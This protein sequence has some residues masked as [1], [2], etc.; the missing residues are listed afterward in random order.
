MIVRDEITPRAGKVLVANADPEIMRILEVNLVY[1]N[2]QV[3]PAHNS[4]EALQVFLQDKFDA[5]ILDQDVL[6]AEGAEISNRLKELSTNIPIILIG[7]QPP[8]KNIFSP[9]KTAMSYITKPFNPGEVVALIQRQLGPKDRTA[10]RLPA[11][12][13]ANK[14][15]LNVRS[16]RAT[17]TAS[18]SGKYPNTPQ[19]IDS[20]QLAMDVNRKEAREALNNIQRI[21]A[22]LMK[23]APPELIDSFDILVSDVQEMAVLGNRSLY[24][25]ADYKN[26]L[27]VQQERSQERDSDRSA[28]VVTVLAI[29]RNL[30]RSL[31]AKQLFSSESGKRVAKYSLAIAREMKMPAADIQALYQAG[32][33]KDL[34][35]AFS[36][37]EVIE[38]TAS[39]NRDAAAALKNKLNQIWKA[40]VP[41]SFLSPA[42]NLLVCL[43][44]RYDGTGGRFGLKGKDILLGA[45]VL[46]VADAFDRLTSVRSPRVQTADLAVDEVNKESG[47]SYDPHVVSA[48]LMLVK[49]N[50]IGPALDDI[51]LEVDAGIASRK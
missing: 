17:P 5:L 45:R 2:L 47:L 10:A 21:I 27:E 33:L 37:P 29:C 19:N 44:E 8:Q 43:P 30:A 34:A 16:K 50:E 13:Q 14:A 48:L 32:L 28:M 15:V 24:L 25:A 3:V 46:A 6:D 23:T 51:E 42:C 18:A 12:L 41:I 11:R 31:Q 20:L 9:G 38:R 22:L 1:A 26:Q 36:R 7:S 35:L 49:R 40:L 4:A 39:I